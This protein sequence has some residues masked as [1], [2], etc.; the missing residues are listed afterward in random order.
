MF[1]HPSGWP[2]SLTPF[3][4]LFRFHFLREADLDHSSHP[5]L[6]FPLLTFPFISYHLLS[7]HAWFFLPV[8]AR[9]QVLLGEV[10]YSFVSCTQV[11]RT[12][13]GTLSELL[14]FDWM[15]EQMNGRAR[16]GWNI[17]HGI[18]CPRAKQMA[19]PPSSGD[20]LRRAMISSD[21]NGSLTSA[22]VCESLFS[23]SPTCF[24]DFITLSSGLLRQKESENCGQ[25]P[26]DPDNKYVFTSILWHMSK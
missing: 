10:L 14:K 15:N 17:V 8:C 9:M 13:L 11:P 7:H 21:W 25:D 6:S 4:S 24:L 1:Y 19:E 2:S 23:L 3:R 5:T 26:D 20:L 18:L 22:T 16:T 12:V